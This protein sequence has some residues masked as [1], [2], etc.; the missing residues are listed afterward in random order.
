MPPAL[1]IGC[2]G[3]NYRHWR[4]AFYPA[5]VPARQWFGFYARV[6]DTVE[7]NN[8]FYRLPESSTFDAW[9]DHAPDD[10]LYAVKASRFLT[11]LKRLREPEEP[12]LRLFERACRLQ[13]HLGPVLYQLP[14]SFHC[15]LVRLDDFLAV[16][17]RTLG[18]LGGTP[19]R[20]RIR[21]VVE[22]RH[23]SWYV[24]ETQSVLRA[25]GAVMCLH[26]RRGSAVFEP[27]DTPFSYVRFHGPGGRYSGR[28]D[29]GRMQYWAEVLAAQWRAG[30]DVFAYFNND[31]GGMAVV[32]AQELRAL[33]VAQLQEETLGMR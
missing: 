19:A 1:R 4:G 16:L 3:W 20:H 29:T 31:A 14:A 12:V 18:E 10:F 23:P 24:D 28:Y 15:D 5:D 26:D 7:I 22:F 13:H 33:T 30:R 21:H 9:R 11:H 17:P 27:L 8:T 6:F 25:H 2:S 32:N